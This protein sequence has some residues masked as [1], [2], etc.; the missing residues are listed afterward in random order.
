MFSV[1]TVYNG[2]YCPFGVRGTAMYGSRVPLNVTLLAIAFK[3]RAI[4]T[5]T[6]A[7]ALDISE[8]G[9]RGETI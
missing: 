4:A 6:G 2:T 9:C 3:L 1:E 5:R 8:A 7:Q